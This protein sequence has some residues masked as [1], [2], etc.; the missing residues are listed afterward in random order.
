MLSSEGRKLRFVSLLLCIEMRF[1]F[2]HLASAAAAAAA[3]EG[4]FPSTLPPCLPSSISSENAAR[5]IC[6]LLTK[7]GSPCDQ[8]PLPT[9]P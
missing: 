3:A 4:M 5:S 7:E 6:L 8:T 1:T 9:P 2:Q